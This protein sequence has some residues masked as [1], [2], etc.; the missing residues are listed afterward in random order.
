MGPGYMPMLVFWV[1]MALGF[2]C[3]IALPFAG[4]ALVPARC[5]GDLAVQACADDPQVAF[6]A[7]RDLARI[8]GADDH[9]RRVVR[10]EPALPVAAQHRGVDALHHRGIQLRELV[11]K[12]F[13]R[14]AR[15]RLHQ[16]AADVV[17]CPLGKEK[18]CMWSSS[19]PAGGAT[20]RKPAYR[21]SVGGPASTASRARTSR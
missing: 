11:G 18:V 7:V 19:P 2:A 20:G 10:P 8:Y 13:P 6:H 14:G 3:V 16:T 9:E 5:G 15:Q 4:D 12:Q 1:L 17:A 21:H